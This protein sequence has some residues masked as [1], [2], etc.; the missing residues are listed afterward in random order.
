MNKST[1]V[2]IIIFAYIIL[3]ERSS[4]ALLAMLAI[5]L[6]GTTLVIFGE[7]SGGAEGYD[8][9]VY[10]YLILLVTPVLIAMGIIAMRNMRKMHESVVTTYMNSTLLVV[11]LI[12]VFASG[13][14][15][16]PWSQFSWLHW[17]FL[18]LLALANVGTQ[19]FRFRAVQRSE[20]SKLQ[21]FVFSQIIF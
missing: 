10:D 4:L 2:F 6:A 9:H 8:R 3:K 11:M 21:P 15:L 14:D 7:E 20:V 16:S 18:V 17:G 19:I 13:S 1:C 12:V 5:S